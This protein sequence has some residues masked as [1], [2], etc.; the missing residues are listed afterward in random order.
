M[1]LAYSLT[2]QEEPVLLE[3][4]TISVS[5]PDAKGTYRIDWKSVFTACSAEDVVLDR[6]PIEGQRGWK[7]Y[8][9]Y[10]GLS[11]R[12]KDAATDVQVHTEKVGSRSGPL[13]GN[14]TAGHG[15]WT[16]P[17]S[18]ANGPPGSPSLNIPE[19]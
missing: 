12:F 9:G 10:A 16:T 11:V 4:R 5:A 1:K 14:T 19:I 2:K 3:E 7:S 17:G 18:S 6:T 13:V 15:R 8:G